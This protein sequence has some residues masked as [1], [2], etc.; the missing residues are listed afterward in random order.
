M[1]RWQY[2][3]RREEEATNE[4]Q[5][6][7]GEDQYLIQHFARHSP[8]Q[9]AGLGNRVVSEILRGRSKCRIVPCCGN[10]IQIEYGKMVVYPQAGFLYCA[11][12]AIELMRSQDHHRSARA[13][14]LT[15]HGAWRK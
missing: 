7:P 3:Q 1:L 6:G 5:C 12:R 2:K 9:S 15:S 13:V 4:K 11:N 8:A 14:D 10:V